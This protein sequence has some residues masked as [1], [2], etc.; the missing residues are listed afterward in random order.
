MV[1]PLYTAIGVIDGRWKPMLF[2]RLSLRPHGFGRLKRSLPD[3]SAK[4]LRQQL[5]EM[6]ADGLV[7]KHSLTPARLGVRYAITRYG[8]TLGPVFE[9]L[10]RWGSRHIARRDAELGTLVTAPRVVAGRPEPAE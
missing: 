2:H 6:V 10:W 8:R 4:V 1:C 7:V 3:V 5:R 9:T